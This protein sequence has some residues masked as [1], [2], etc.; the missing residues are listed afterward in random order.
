M[1]RLIFSIIIIVSTKSFAMDPD[2]GLWRVCE[3]WGEYNNEQVI[4]NETKKNMKAQGMD[5]D[6]IQPEDKRSLNKLK[7]KFEKEKKV[8]EKNTKSKFKAAMCQS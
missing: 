2:G 3:V 8:F 6:E 5:I 7:F 4:Y 1:G